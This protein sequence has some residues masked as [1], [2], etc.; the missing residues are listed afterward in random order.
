MEIPKKYL[1]KYALELWKAVAL[2]NADF[3]CKRPKCP[4]CYN[5]QF[6][7]GLQVHHIFPRTSYSIRHNLLN[8]CVLCSAS[9]NFWAH[10][11]DPTIQEQV[12]AFYKKYYN[13]ELLKKLKTSQSKLDYFSITENLESELQ[14]SLI[15]KHRIEFVFKEDILKRKVQVENLTKKDKNNTCFLQSN[16]VYQINRK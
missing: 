12:I 9:H 10:S 14:V 11:K 6:T 1:D 16:F 15:E 7:K 3:K 2:I 8:S 4:Y 13:Y 5:V